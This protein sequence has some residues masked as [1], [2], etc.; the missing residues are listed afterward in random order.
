MPRVAQFV[1][2]GAFNVALAQQRTHFL[3]A[4]ARYVDAV[5]FEELVEPE[6][7]V[8]LAVFDHGVG[9]AVDVA[10]CLPHSLIHEDAGVDALHI[11]SVGH[12]LPPDLFD[13]AQQLDA[14]RA[15]IPAA[16]EAAVNFRALEDEA[17]A[18]AQ[19]Y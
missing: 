3:G 4:Q 18:F 19:G 15:V 14:Q 13:V 1:A 2:L 6:A 17:F 12:G 8:G 5:F 7:L 10:R 16:V 11:L 9:K